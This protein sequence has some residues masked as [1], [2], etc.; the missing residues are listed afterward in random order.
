[1]DELPQL[2]NFLKGEISPVDPRRAIS[3]KSEAYELCQ[4]RRVLEAK[5]GITGLWQVEGRSRVAFDE[6]VRL[7][8]RY[9]MARSFW[10]DLKILMQTPDAVIMGASAY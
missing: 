8:V 1:L 6:M 3:Y 7:D 2:Y 9:A 4:R 5:P 10:L